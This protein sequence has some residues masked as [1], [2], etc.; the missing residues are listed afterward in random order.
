M[1][2]L[3]AEC[4]TDYYLLYTSKP[5]KGPPSDTRQPERDADHS[6]PSSIDIKN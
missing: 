4:V 3:Q 5:G 6:H 1:I 2:G